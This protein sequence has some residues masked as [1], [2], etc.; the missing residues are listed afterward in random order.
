MLGVYVYQFGIACKV[1]NA[2]SMKVSPLMGTPV[3]IFSF[4]LAVL[5]IMKT[6]VRISTAERS[7]SYPSRFKF[8][9]LRF[10]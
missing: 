9:R 1:Q 10:R 3:H 5:L 2:I 8:F 7:A 4:S 6:N